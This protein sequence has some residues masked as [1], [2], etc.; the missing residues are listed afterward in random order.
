[1]SF[2][3]GL[4]RDRIHQVN[5][6]ALRKARQR[7]ALQRRL[8]GESLESRQMLD[9]D[10]LVRFVLTARDVETDELLNNEEGVVEVAADSEQTLHYEVPID[11]VF[12]LEVSVQDLRERPDDFGVFRA[13]TDIIVE[14]K[15]VLEPAIGEVQELIFDVSQLTAADPPGMI[16]FGL[17]T[18]ESLEPIPFSD[19]LGASDSITQ[20]NI[21]DVVVELNPLVT[22]TSQL[23]INTFVKPEIGPGGVDGYVIEIIY[24]DPS[25]IGLDMPMLTVDYTIGDEQQP[26]VENEFDV[27]VNGVPNGDRLFHFLETDTRNN[28][29]GNPPQAIPSSVYGSTRVIGDFDAS[30]PNFDVFDEVGGLGPGEGAIRVAIPEFSNLIAYDVFSIPVIARSLADDLVV[31]IDP[32]DLGDQILLYGT[33]TDREMVLLDEIQLGGNSR[34][35]LDVIPPKPKLEASNTSETLIED[36]SSITIDLANLVDAD[37]G[38]LSYSLPDFPSFPATSQL[39]TLNLDGT[40][41]TYTPAPDAFGTEALT[42]RVARDGTT[43]FDQ[44][45]ITLSIDPV[46]DPPVA[47]DNEFSTDEDSVLNISV[48]E[49]LANDTDV[50]LN[51]TLS[52]VTFGT[53]SDGTIELEGD[54]I[55]YTPGENYFGPDSFTY[56]IEDG[57]GVQRSAEV[58][59]TVVPVNDPPTANGESAQTEPNVP[60][61]F[62]ISDLLSNDSAGPLEPNQTLSIVAVDGLIESESSVVIDGSVVRYTPATDFNGTDG[63]TYTV[64]DGLE[65][66]TADVA[67]DVRFEFQV[68]NLV[69]PDGGSNDITVRRIA[70][71]QLEIIDN[72]TSTNNVLLRRPLNTVE[73]LVIT[74]GDTSVDRIEIDHSS[75]GFI[76]FAEGST[77]IEVLGGGSDDDELVLKGISS[78]NTLLGNA[79]AQST[80]VLSGLLATLQSGSV[81][82]AHTIRG[83]ESIR[84]EDV[85]QVT[86]SGNAELNIDADS[87]HID[88]EFTVNLS[89]MTSINGGT[90]SSTSPLALGAG[91][92]LSGH[93]TVAARLVS[94]N[95]STITASG[96]DLTLGDLGFSTSVDL[97]GQ[98][99]T[100]GNT[101]TLLD[102][103]VANIRGTVNLGDGNG[104]AGIL[105][106]AN[107]LD[108]QPTAE[109]AGHGSIVTGNDGA[110]GLLN[111]GNLIGAS[112]DRPLTVPGRLSG[113]GA[114]NHVILDG[115][116]DP[117]ATFEN[118]LD[119]QVE[120][121]ANAS[122]RVDIGGTVAGSSYD[123][124]RFNPS[125]MIGG[126]I[127]VDFINGFS[128]SAGHEFE[129]IAGVES[130]SGSIDPANLDLPDLV[131]GLKWNVNQSATALTLQVI[132]DGSVFSED[133]RVEVGPDNQIIVR[134]ADDQPIPIAGSVLTLDVVPTQKFVPAE[135][136]QWSVEDTQ[137]IDGQVFQIA[138]NG[139][140][141]LRI[142]G[143]A[144]T[145]FIDRFDINSDGNTTASDALAVINELNGP[146]FSS[147]VTSQLD[148]PDSLD[149]FPNIYFDTNGDGLISAVDALQVIN[150]LI[151]G[152]GGGEPLVPEGE[153]IVIAPAAALA[154]PAPQRMSTAQLELSVA[155]LAVDNKSVA[156]AAWSGWADD[157][158]PLSSLMVECSHEGGETPADTLEMLSQ[159]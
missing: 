110:S 156:D 86:I 87:L 14:S 71:D 8:I 142:R 79:D 107:G 39:G 108:V 103:D 101:V 20:R 27:F 19:F 7:R 75:G 149:E 53:V 64:S 51:D 9:G 125:V 106:A 73:S 131:N 95:G 132:L 120:L 117:S 81:Q 54:T 3:L 133:V 127:D 113:S 143:A 32:P 78:A 145:N 115:P 43:D 25:L 17:E 157:D 55:L 82:I 105:T 114:I 76:A 57:T 96:G 138:T 10:D 139:G 66:V 45:T 63:F 12:K 36:Q 13:V 68:V 84:V 111:N 124:F 61:E 22:S 112:A 159:R 155:T 48:A 47:V 136:Q 126:R 4:R 147:S 94:P 1:M 152:G 104:T 35:F 37:P 89:G 141:T 5:R 65:T 137:K 30:D 121:G 46:N 154:G 128:P 69:L 38:T 29:G 18:G 150:R 49:L 92:T 140:V 77:T 2:F 129:I 41:L 100:G 50:D 33:A 6:R 90:L 148:D 56:T 146:A 67:I 151:L 153:S 58:L 80:S 26:V 23:R 144:W 91:E 28:L 109:V 21:A 72:S 15:G 40:V 24:D 60:I 99:N 134:G 34:L 44:A 16:A 119:G 122:L 123:R 116:W 118:R 88:S 83:F 93:G 135:T 62:L 52:L 70:G 158:T 42:F 130:L 98:L 31:R 59:I 97:A 11:T 102:S 74:G 85:R